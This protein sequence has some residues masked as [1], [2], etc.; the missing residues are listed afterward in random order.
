MKN[1]GIALRVLVLGL[2][3]SVTASAQEAANPDQGYIDKFLKKFPKI[4]TP[5]TPETYAT[6]ERFDKLY[7]GDSLAQTPEKVKKT[8][9]DTGG[10]AW[11]VSYQMMS[12]NAMYQ[13]THDVKY[14]DA[15]LLCIK[16][17]LDATDEK[18]G[19][20]L[21]NGRVVKA[22]G[23][24]KYAERGRAVFPVHTG[25]IT[26]PMYEWAAWAKAAPG[27]GDAH[28]ADIQAVLDGAREAIEVH[29]RQ[30]REGPGEREG[31]YIGLDQEDK[32]ENK[33]LP[34]NRQSAMGWALWASWKVTGN[35]THRDRA[36]R[37]GMYIKNRLTPS[38]DGAYYWTY[39]LP[40]Q[41]VTE[42]LPR[43]SVKG[44]DTS[45]GGLTM[46]LP[47]ILGAAGEV[48]TKE[49]MQRL[50]KTVVNGFGR[51]GNGVLGGNVT[52]APDFSPD[53]VCLPARW[54]VLAAYDPEVRPRIW[55]F[56]LNYC[57]NPSPSEL[58]DLILMRE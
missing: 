20:Q 36:L 23:C 51:F 53:Y 13:A 29:E 30:W 8:A 16:A 42:T 27:Y 49:D 22:W 2:V 12:F 1:L 21:W 32:M 3:C 35:E 41:P 38:P 47:F 48:F 54:L 44:E 37:I 7:L 43:E 31:H 57:P 58:A 46:A 34:G 6:Q 56:Y 19:L 39:W 33:P 25:I 24:T 17:V 4:E 50:A 45:H 14:L 18:R 9:N 28:A 40:E 52:G 10:L 26:A 5:L 55:A 15:N 11:G